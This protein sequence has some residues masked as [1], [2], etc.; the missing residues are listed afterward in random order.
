M[1]LLLVG[2][3]MLG[4]LVNQRLKRVPPAYVW[5]DTLPLFQSADLRMCNLE[6]VL[7]DNGTPWMQTPKVFHFRS[8]AKN[9]Q[10][11]KA[12]G[13]DGVSLANNH[14]LD[15]GYEALL[16]MLDILDVHGVRHSGAGRY[17]QAASRPA[18]LTCQSLRIACIAF[19]D[20][21][22]EWEATPSMPGVFYVPVEVED[23]RAKKLLKIVS[24]LRP[25]VDWLI[26]SAHWGGNWGYQ[27]EDEQV[28]L[29][30]ALI[31]H[32]ADIIFGHS[33]HVFRG[34]EIYHSR[35]I[36]YS[37]GDFV[38][39]YRVDEVERNDQSFI[40]IVEIEDRRVKQLELYPT[41]IR[42]L[43][44]RL[45]RGTQAISIAEKMQTLC[46]EFDT[47]TVWDKAEGRL[48][49]PVNWN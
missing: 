37:C 27:P 26:V 36:L 15:Y 16:E 23:R 24:R 13:I 41:I 34:I 4:R 25:Q 2:D 12:A 35:P 33:C 48:T 22:P 7:S 1:K 8:D 20:N 9:V 19:T 45:A 3:V 10:A 28:S 43:R 14:I 47:G 32:G 5:G 29:A 40:F 46:R 42:H 39:D 6:C 38:D 30:H 49:I 21:E 17:A 18:I 11:L 31:E 44:A